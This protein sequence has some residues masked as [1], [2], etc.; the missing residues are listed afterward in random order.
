MRAKYSKARMVIEMTG[1]TDDVQSAVQFMMQ[2]LSGNGFPSVQISYPETCVISPVL[3]RPRKA[4][5]AV[6]P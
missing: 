4:K 1:S 3:V 6:T 2:F 5:G